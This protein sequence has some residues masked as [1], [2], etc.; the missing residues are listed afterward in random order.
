VHRNTQLASKINNADLSTVY[1][2]QT[3]A[4]FGNYNFEH[5]G[6]DV[7][8]NIEYLFVRN[9]GLSV[10]QGSTYTELNSK[11]I[12]IFLN[13]PNNYN[14]LRMD[15]DTAN[16]FITS[17]TRDGNVNRNVTLYISFSISNFFP[18]TGIFLIAQ[19]NN[20][21]SARI[22]RIEVYDGQNK[23]GELTRR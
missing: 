9:L 1:T 12:L 16:A 10:G 23:I 21:I 22:T 8:V 7:G 2:F 3:G 6:F 5:G 14:F 20:S 17:R 15:R 13:N 11:A 18:D 19:M 4:N